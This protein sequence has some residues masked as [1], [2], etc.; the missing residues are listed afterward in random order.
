MTSV[1]ADISPYTLSFSSASSR[2]VGTQVANQFQLSSVDGG[3][4]WKA[5]S[6]PSVFGAVGCFDA[7]NWWWIGPGVQSKTSDAGTT[8]SHIRSLQVPAP[9]PDSLQIIDGR[10]LLFG[11]MVGSAPLVEGTDDGGVSWRTILLPATP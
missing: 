6:T 7:L 3:R 5:I 9:L 11:A 4:S 10:H 8:W 1:Y 2:A